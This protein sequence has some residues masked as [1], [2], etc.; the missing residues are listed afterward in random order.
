MKTGHARHCRLFL[1]PH[2]D[3]GLRRRSRYEKKLVRDELQPDTPKQKQELLAAWRCSGPLGVVGELCQGL[4]RAHQRP[5]QHVC[6]RETLPLTR[7]PARLLVCSFARLG[8]AVNV[9]ASVVMPLSLF[10]I[11]ASSAER[12]F[13]CIDTPAASSVH[14]RT[15]KGHR[16]LTD[17]ITARG[18]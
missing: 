1:G 12:V 10:P 4:Y 11:S 8:A 16:G 18:A 15:S 6:L 7:P 3:L 17:L 5:E 9:A 2:R 13:R 14:T